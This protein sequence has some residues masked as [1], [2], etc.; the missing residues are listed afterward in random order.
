MTRHE[1]R[2]GCT[3]SNSSLVRSVS[4][5]SK[6]KASGRAY[7][8]FDGRCIYFARYGT[9]SS[10]EA[11]DRLKSEWIQNGGRLPTAQHEATV[12]EVVVAYTEFAMGYYRKD[13][14]QTDEVRMIKTAIKFARQLYGRTPAAEFGPLALKACREQMLAKDWCRSHINKQVDRLKRMFKWATENEIISG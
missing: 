13:G 9:A 2:E 7:A 8:R 6:H 4:K 5:Y 14:R 1:G 10:R 11:F 3:M 12:T